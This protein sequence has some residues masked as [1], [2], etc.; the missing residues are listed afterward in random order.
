MSGDIELLEISHRTGQMEMRQQILD[1]LAN[2]VDLSEE[3][4]ETNILHEVLMTVSE[5]VMA[6]EPFATDHQQIQQVIVRAELDAAAH[7]LFRS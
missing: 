5:E 4:T 6:V 7:R 1:F 2:L 3:E